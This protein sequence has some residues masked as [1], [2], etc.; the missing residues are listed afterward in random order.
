[1]DAVRLACILLITI[2]WWFGTELAMYEAMEHRTQA[3]VKGS[4]RE[5]SVYVKGQYVGQLAMTIQ[6]A[7]RVDGR[8]GHYL[9]LALKSHG[10][11]ADKV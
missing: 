11:S 2:H 6:E 9:K 5:Y 8:D 3:V 1:M 10:K 7:K 4:V